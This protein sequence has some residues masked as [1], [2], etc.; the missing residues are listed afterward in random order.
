MKIKK[1]NA[2]KLCILLLPFFI[3]SAGS[4][5]ADTIILKSG[6][7]LKGII[8]KEYSDRVILRIPD[9]EVGI[10]KNLISKIVYLRPE[11]N[12]LELGNKCAKRG[13]FGEALVHYRKA[14]RINRDFEEAKDAIARVREA[15]QSQKEI[16]EERLRQSLGIIIK[17][18]GNEIKVASVDARSPAFRAGI[19]HEDIIETIW[20]AH[21]KYEKLDK[22]IALLTGEKGASVSL[23][24]KR[25]VSPIRRKIRWYQKEFVGIGISL[26]MK[27]RGL[28]ITNVSPGQPADKVG[29]KP[30]DRIV[31]IEGKSIRYT[32]LSEAIKK[33][34]GQAGIPLDLTITRKVRIVRGGYKKIKAD[35]SLVL[36]VVKEEEIAGIGVQI[37]LTS[38]GPKVVNVLYRSPAEKAGLKRGDLL[39]RIDEKPVRGLSSKESTKLLKGEVGSIV[40]TAIERDIS[41]IRQKIPGK[42]F[43][44]IGCTL[45]KGENGFEI[46]GLLPDGAAKK[47]GIKKGDI[48]VRVEDKDITNK[49][50]FSQFVEEIRGPV[51]AEL[52]LTIRRNLAIKRTK[53]R[54]Q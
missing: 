12:L 23:T 7:I 25:Q 4:L 30:G 48:I 49:I 24:I 10:Y 29:L 37:V 47:A 22:A 8:V 41:L 1:I 2:A 35:P 38:K 17:K 13:E 18:E 53:I 28:T 32:G 40:Q 46:N 50:S 39:V 27:E 43:A 6:S 51:G 21:L 44:G 20:D 54:V 5:Y 16:S 42:N 3:C 19:K 33:M 14:L 45:S 34:A 11:Q 9:G 15:K 36:P 26:S 52:T 31:A